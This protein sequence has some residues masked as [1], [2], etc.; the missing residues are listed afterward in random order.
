MLTS[1]PAVLAAL[2]ESIS[3]FISTVVAA[4][5]ASLI[6]K[7]FADRKSLERKLHLAIEDIAYLLEVEKI[8]CERNAKFHKETYK[9]KS[10]SDAS[11][12]GLFW[13]GKFTPG[14]AKSML[15]LDFP[16]GK[17][18]EVSNQNEELL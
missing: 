13:S 17:V 10:R 11:N 5:A 12:K 8:H 7:Q 14:R 16:S 2:I 15:L 9:L 4:I 1:D 6:G 3:A 18:K